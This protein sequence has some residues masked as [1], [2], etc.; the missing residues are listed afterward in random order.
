MGGFIVVILAGGLGLL[1]CILVARAFGRWQG[2][3][4]WAMA[5]PLVLMLGVTLNILV[6]TWLDP[7]S[8]NLWPIE[9]VFM[10]AVAS[11]MMGILYLLHWLTHRV[12]A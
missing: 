2:W 12:R 5:I 6:A 11:A 8:H 3:W 4:R 10:Y 9:L 7:T 1:L